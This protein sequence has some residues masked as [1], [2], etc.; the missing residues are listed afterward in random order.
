MGG[1][2]RSRAS[3][4]T[5]RVTR[6]RRIPSPG[7]SGSGPRAAALRKGHP[8]PSRP[9]A[10]TRPALALCSEKPSPS[11]SRLST[12]SP[13]DESTGPWARLGA[14]A[15]PPA[16][17]PSLSLCLYLCLPLY[18]CL[19]LSLSICLSVCLCLSLSLSLCVC[20]S[21]S[22][23][24][25]LSLC[26]CLCL[27]LSVCLSFSL[28]VF[29]SLSVSVFLSVSVSL[30]LCLC[31]CLC[32]S[33]SVSLSV[34]LS[35]SLSVSVSVSLSLSLSPSPCLC[36]WPWRFSPQSLLEQLLIHQPPEP[37]Q[38]MIHHLELDNDDVPKIV[39]LGPPASGKTTIGMWLCKH[40]RS[41][42]VT[43]DS[44][45]R[46]FSSLAESHG[47]LQRPPGQRL[48]ALSSP[49]LV[50]MLRLRL[51]EDDCVR[52]GWILDSIPQT[53]EETLRIQTAGISPR[54]VKIYH[55]TFDWPSDIDVQNRLVV[56]PG[57]SEPE[58]VKRLLEY[59]RN[60]TEVTPAYPR[61]LKAISA[62]Q[63]CM[64]VFYQA[65]TYVQSSHRSNAPFTP[66][67]V[68]LGP[69]GSGRRLQAA[70]LAQRYGLVD[71]CCGQL[72]KE[73]VAAQDNLGEVIRTYFEKDMTVP[74]KLI[75]KALGPRL[76]RPD[77]VQRGWVLHGFPRDPDQARL[78]DDLGHRPNR[79]FILNVPLDT[80]ME[81]LTLRRTDPVTG[82]R[83]HLL[84]KPPPTMEAQQRLLQN[85][86]DAEER[87]K[88][89]LDQYYR[90]S[91]EL[92]A[93]YPGAITLNGDQ[94]PYT[95]FEYI[96]SGVINPLPKKVH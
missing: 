11:P 10:R 75:M 31:L 48:E 36:S 92:E 70:L 13:E 79:V 14:C 34:S 41:T 35:F 80:I 38:F 77:C 50:Q 30:Y 60:I 42:L 20:L 64:D 93:C 53:R 16:R 76:D 55:T 62:D 88:A 18:L 22:L 37:I 81:R 21:F 1:S 58:T 52:Q 2:R 43:R 39:I 5:A 32:L 12:P 23:S 78:L 72:L 26:L 69:V 71:V 85:P 17:L 63:P 68:L 82:E 8:P 3:P 33:L 24:V 73:T 83:Y 51:A 25:S 15:S 7:E 57:I 56:P 46:R 61:I 86:Q 74:D 19:S 67:V 47:H 9:A 90:N 27:C 6:G 94:D 84:H 29:V 45:S 49:L 4:S 40:L 95:V 44:L 28:S 54:H 89:K 96:E 87:V 66:R 65:L 91:A 59:H